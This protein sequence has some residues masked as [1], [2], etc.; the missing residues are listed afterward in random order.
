MIS[1]LL[2]V[3]SHP[4]YDPY[5]HVLSSSNQQFRFDCKKNRTFENDQ[6]TE[7]IQ[8]FHHF[9]FWKQW[10]ELDIPVNI[11]WRTF[12][13]FCL[14]LSSLCVRKYPMCTVEK[15]RLTVYWLLINVLILVQDFNF[16]SVIPNNDFL[17]RTPMVFWRG[18]YMGFN[19]YFPN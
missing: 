7:D 6:N 12:F 13:I 5:E 15:F 1:H 2:S 4:P 19:E 16:F 17:D 9:I 3:Y 8:M 11:T 10:F 18:L 14:L